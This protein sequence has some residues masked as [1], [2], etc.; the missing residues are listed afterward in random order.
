MDS[1]NGE[2]SDPESTQSPHIPSTSAPFTY[3]PYTTPLPHV[4]PALSTPIYTPSP[5]YYPYPIHPNQFTVP[6]LPPA[7]PSAP[8]RAMPPSSA[9]PK[10]RGRDQDTHRMSGTGFT[11]QNQATQPQ[12]LDQVKLEE[13][14]ITIQQA[15]WSIGEFLYYFSRNE[16]ENGVTIRGRTRT[17]SGML[18]SFLRG[19]SNRTPVMIVQEWIKNPMGRPQSTRN[20]QNAHE[21]LSHIF[22]PKKPPEEL[23]FTYPALTSWAAQLVKAELVLGGFLK[24]LK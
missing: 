18:S 11:P 3:T 2:D 14:L 15:R 12:D 20:S 24:F 19:E 1:C 4:T 23:R 13:I 6:T 8:S 7:T 9:K 17:H 22:S 21:E 16:D 5:V 10:S